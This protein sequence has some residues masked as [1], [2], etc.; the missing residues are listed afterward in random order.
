MTLDIVQTL[1]LC[2][3]DPMWSDHAEVNKATLKRAIVEILK[4]RAA[5]G[6]IANQ[7]TLKELKQNH[8]GIGDI[9]Y[10]YDRMIEVARDGIK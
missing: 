5:L 2:A 8:E 4:L 3:N 1:K 9:E 6:N 7:M 10:A